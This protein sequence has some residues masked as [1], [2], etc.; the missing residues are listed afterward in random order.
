MSNKIYQTIYLGRR[1]PLPGLK[2]SGLHAALFVGALAIIG[3]LLAS[4]H[5]T[6]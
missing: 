1:P 2:I 5:D 4:G 3:M 6:N